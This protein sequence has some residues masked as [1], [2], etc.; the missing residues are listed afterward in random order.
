MRLHRVKTQVRPDRRSIPTLGM[1]T[2]IGL[3]NHDCLSERYSG[4]FCADQVLL[5]LDIYT[6]S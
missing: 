2:M 6:H 5:T 1:L 4:V 3:H